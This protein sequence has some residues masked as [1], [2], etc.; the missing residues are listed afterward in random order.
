[1]AFIN[2]QPTGWL[3]FLGIKNF[4]RNP[5]QV[6]EVLAPTWDLSDLY[7]ASSRQ[8]VITTGTINAVGTY[9]AFSPPAGRVWHVWGFGVLSVA[10]NAANVID[11]SPMIY[12]VPLGHPVVI[13]NGLNTIAD[14]TVA[15]SRVSFGID[16]PVIL[17]PGD[18][19]GFY[20]NRYVGPAL[21]YTAH[22][23]Y[24]VLQA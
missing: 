9:P 20:C 24:T 6:A 13:G 21:T 2:K 14:G 10:M 22:M 3:G 23:L 19:I 1:V 8:L 18:S 16:R 12:N 7:L 4:G 17:V 15:G 11:A 5:S